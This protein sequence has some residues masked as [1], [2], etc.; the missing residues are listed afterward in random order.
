M[1]AAEGDEAEAT[2][3]AEPPIPRVV[4]LSELDGSRSSDVLD[5]RAAKFLPDDNLIQANADFR[6][7]TDMADYWADEYGVPRGN[8]AI[9][10]V[11]HEWFEQALVETVIG[12]QA[13]QGERRWSPNDIDTILSEE[14]LTAAVMQRYHVANAVKRTLGAKMGSLKTGA[15]A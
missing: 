10:D 3:P 1:L 7:F 2:R 5:D 12:C 8:Q 11:V 4:W 13:L 14:A 6:V 9:V 15:G